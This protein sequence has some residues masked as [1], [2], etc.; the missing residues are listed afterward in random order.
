ML[1]SRPTDIDSQP[2]G[3]DYWVR[4]A[5]NQGSGESHFVYKGVDLVVHPKR[6]AQLTQEGRR[7]LV[8]KTYK[9]RGWLDKFVSDIEEGVST[10]QAGGGAE[11]D[12]CLGDK[13][14][15]EIEARSAGTQSTDPD[16]VWWQWLTDEELPIL[17]GCWLHQT[18]IMSLRY[19]ITK[20]PMLGFYTTNKE[21]E[22]GAQAC[23]TRTLWTTLQRLAFARKQLAAT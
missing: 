12:K 10:L 11:A 20:N 2:T 3:L 9:G 1:A 18:G 17:L 22:W 6:A 16:R 21:F 8:E 5:T 7:V 4:R 14:R 23:Q 19:E 13:I 15:E